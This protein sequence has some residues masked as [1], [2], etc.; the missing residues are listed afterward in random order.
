VIEHVHEL[1]DYLDLCSQ[2]APRAIEPVVEVAP[3]AVE[4][5][6]FARLGPTGLGE[7]VRRLA[8]RVGL[9]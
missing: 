8:E 4:G 7:R 5:L 3:Q 6:S 1:P 9:R 2:L